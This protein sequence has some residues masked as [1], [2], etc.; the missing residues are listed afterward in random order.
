MQIPFKIKC[1][2]CN[3]EQTIFIHA[4]DYSITN[5][6]A[7]GEP[8][9]AV[10]SGDYTIGIK[11]LI[12][13]DYE[14]NETKDYSLS[15]IL[16]ASAV[17]CEL[18]R[19]H[20]KWKEIG[21]LEEGRD[22]AK[23]ELDK[24]FR[25]YITVLTKIRKTARLM[26]PNGFDEFVSMTPELRES[27]DKGFQSLSLDRLSSDLVKMLFWP[28]NQIIH[29]GE[30]RFDE[31]EARQRHN[32]ALFAVLTLKSMDEYKRK[33]HSKEGYDTNDSF[34]PIVPVEEF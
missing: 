4:M 16:S 34:S 10:L 22:I 28:R 15:I 27:I 30:V 32:I 29:S 17:D 12:R 23:E 2:L 26:Y 18:S 3:L 7:C 1:R 20:H 24:I 11:L 19:L 8:Y 21:E 25:G 14:L 9:N 31:E 13:S 5:N 6:C 33:N